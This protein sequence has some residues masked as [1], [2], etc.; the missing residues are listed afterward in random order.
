MT[1]PSS[2]ARHTPIE[3]VSG[4]MLAA[5][6]NRMY[7]MSRTCL[8][9]LMMTCPL[10]PPLLTWIHHLLPRA[11]L[12]RL[13]IITPRHYHPAE[14]HRQPPIPRITIFFIRANM[15]YLSRTPIYRRKQPCSK[16]NSLTFVTR[17]PVAARRVRSGFSAYG[18]QA[19]HLLRA[20]ARVPHLV[21]NRLLRRWR[22]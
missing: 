14:V 21:N 15:T 12:T 13:I 9:S 16:S 19:T 17:V 11:I 10:Y 22:I 2:I 6:R 18:G 8:L 4:P 7:R 5:A 20:R 3:V 1:L